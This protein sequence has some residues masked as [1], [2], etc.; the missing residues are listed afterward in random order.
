MD[1][2][3]SKNELCKKELCKKELPKIILLSGPKR[4]GKDTLA[5]YLNDNYKYEHLKITTKL[6][7]CIKLLFDLNDNDLE[8]I[9]ELVN[10]EWK[11]TPRKMMQ[12]IGTELF[13]YK[14]QEL[15]PNIGRNFWIKSLFNNELINKLTS[16]ED[17]RIVISDLRFIH[18][19]EEIK[20]I[21]IP[22]CHIRIINPKLDYKPDEHIS[23]NELFQMKYEYEIINDNDIYNYY[24]KIDNMMKELIKI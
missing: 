3:N 24:F 1:I 20:K 15:I 10:P 4:C 14:I 22:Y 16:I 12:F 11:T 5:N 7:E 21:N 9:K 17:Y 19:L 23:E 6:K 2:I 13:Q 8:E 18:E